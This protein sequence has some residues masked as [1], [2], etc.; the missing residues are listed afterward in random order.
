MVGPDILGLS[1][2]DALQLM[3]RA[4]QRG[5][6]EEVCFCLAKLLLLTAVLCFTQ[7]CAP[8]QSGQI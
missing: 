6:F 3:A 2:A 7:T 1:V 4:V 5:D 8:V